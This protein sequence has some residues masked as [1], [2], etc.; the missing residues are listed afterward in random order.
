MSEIKIAVTGANGQLG[1]GLQMIAPAHKK[2]N[3][4][5]LSREGLPIENHKRVQDFF[6][7]NKPAYC[8]NCAAYTAV[9]KAESEKENA[10]LIN[11]EATG[12]LAGTCNSFGTKLI[13]ISTDY[14]FD[15]NATSPIKEDDLTS[16][17]N[18]YGVSKLKGEQL[19]MQENKGTIIIRTSW[20][21]SAFGNNFV[22]TM[23]RLMNEKASINVVSDQLGSPTYAADLA[24]VIMQIINSNKFIAGI[25]HYSNEG[26]ISWYDFAL[27]IKKD[28]NSNCE[29]NP[30][31][32]SQYPTAAKRPQY[33]V[34]DKTKI[35][36]VYGIDIKEWRSSL[37]LCIEQLK[38]K[39]YKFSYK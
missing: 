6:R 18:A 30:I 34:L 27:A 13:H 35:K 4:I 21:Y 39:E 12:S 16:P 15:G 19:A 23:I 7:D 17:I 22:K 26:E 8:I 28:I 3:F 5:F 10:F 24:S 2:F 33:S 20:L 32:S 11:A 14:V 25:Y 1:R 38:N 9:D 36:S 31:A 37:A 29:V